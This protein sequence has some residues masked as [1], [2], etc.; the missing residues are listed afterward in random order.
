ME[1]FNKD[2][3]RTTLIESFN[4]SISKWGNR[5]VLE[6]KRDGEYK[7]WTFQEYYNIVYQVSK[8]LIKLG[9]SDGCSININSINS[10]EWFFCFYGSVFAKYIPTGIYTTS[11]AQQCANLFNLSHGSVVFV[12]NKETLMKYISVQDEI[13]NCKAII[14]MEQISTSDQEEI[15]HLSLKT[16]FKIYNWNQFLELGNDVESSLIDKI[17]KSIVTNDIAGII[18]T[19]GTTSQPK[20]VMLTHRNYVCTSFGILR[21]CFYYRKI[22][23]K[24]TGVSFLPL[25]HIAEQIGTLISA[26]QVGIKIVF[27]DK[28]ALKGTLLETLIYTKPSIFFAVPR[29]YQKIQFK[30]QTQ[31][32]SLTG[33]KKFLVDW[34]R[35][36]ALRSFEL[37]DKGQGK[38]Y[39]YYIAEK[40]VFKK[41]K[42]SIGWSQA[43]TIINAAAPLGDDTILFF[44]S[45]GIK[46]VQG[47]GLSETSGA[48]IM[49][50]PEDRVGSIGKP[51]D[52]CQLKIDEKDGE[53]L[54][55]GDSLFKAYFNNEQATNEAIDKDGWFHTGD[56]GSIDKDGFV[57]LTDRKKELIITAGG[58]NIAPTHIENLLLQIPGME[59]AVVVGEKQKFLIAIFTLNL[60]ML[61]LYKG[62]QHEIPETLEEAS[63]DENIIK[64]F[65]ESIQTMVNSKLAQVQTIKRFKILSVQF[66][67]NSD[68]AELTPTKKLKRRIINKK[69]SEEIKSTYGDLYV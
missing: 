45:I 42:E 14:I 22:G 32:D 66:K 58:E 28:D 36:V 53:I 59:D 51:L 54:I 26:M 30:I 47:Y 33:T 50:I 29:I 34:A 43:K 2:N 23:D 62:Y 16:L 38:P 3:E 25:S 49:G 39:S 12:E 46:I 35:K 4:N 10:P 15:N 55:K 60:Q 56:I 48:V 18:F 64:Y 9:L 6:V 65:E 69:Y 8:S 17:S 27:A 67:D 24:E 19:S 44:R 1:N 31:L 21:A 52:C 63:K 20:A 61:K 13:L 57:Y 41:I 68:D 37:E 40:L 7:K 11:S 5:I